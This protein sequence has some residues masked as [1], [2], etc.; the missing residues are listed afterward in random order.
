MA[1]TVCVD[2]NG[3]LDM[4][5]GWRPDFM[6][7]PREGVDDFLRRLNDMGFRVVILTAIDPECIREWLVKHGLERHVADV[8]REKPPATAY[9]DDRAICFRGDFDQTLRELQSFRAHWESRGE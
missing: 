9:I 7:P 8:V 2:F 5:T 3:V 1:R 6:Y 4:Y